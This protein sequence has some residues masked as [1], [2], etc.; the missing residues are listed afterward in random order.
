MENS[1]K[2]G[3]FCESTQYEREEMAV[4]CRL[5]HNSPAFLFIEKNNTYINKWLQLYTLL[6]TFWPLTL[7]VT[8][9]AIA[10]LCSVTKS[11]VK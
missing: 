4:G 11:L 5:Q 7:H 10:K 1:F 8:E 9:D 6:E 3:F 2:L